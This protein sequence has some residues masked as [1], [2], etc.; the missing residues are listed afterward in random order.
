MTNLGVNAH[1]VN[2]MPPTAAGNNNSDYF[3]LKEAEHVDIIIQTGAVTN[4]T[5]FTVREATSNAG[6]S[7]T[8]IVFDYYAISTAASDTWSAKTTATVGGVSTGTTNTLAWIISIDASQLSDGYPYL[9][10]HFSTAGTIKFSAAAV[11]S[12]LRYAT[13]TPLSAID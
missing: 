3:H 9:N 6:A 5:T 8:A 1:V 4:A 13:E 2:I 7:A 12:T 10:V 11:L